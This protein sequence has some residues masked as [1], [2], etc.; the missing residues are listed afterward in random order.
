MNAY[1][2]WFLEKLIGSKLSK[3]PGTAPVIWE[4]TDP[5]ISCTSTWEQA[6]WGTGYSLRKNTHNSLH[7]VSRKKVLRLAFCPD[8]WRSEAE[9]GESPTTHLGSSN[10]WS[11]RTGGASAAILSP[12][13]RLLHARGKVAAAGFCSFCNRPNPGT[14]SLPAPLTAAVSSSY[15]PPRGAGDGKEGEAAVNDRALPPLQMRN[16]RNSHERSR[17]KRRA[18]S[19]HRGEL[20]YSRE[21]FCNLQISIFRIKKECPS[22]SPMEKVGEFG[23]F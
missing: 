7:S 6:T 10:S 14:R 12:P 18:A 2:L 16:W 17:K 23:L 9:G 11:E 4:I 5:P 8:R 20:T 22:P 15:S 1:F 3:A 19:L 13:P 21:D